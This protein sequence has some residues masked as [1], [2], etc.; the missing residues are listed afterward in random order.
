MAKYSTPIFDV[1][2]FTKLQETL[3]QQLNCE[4]KMICRTRTL[5]WFW[6]SYVSGTSES[7]E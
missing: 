1:I 7:F 3:K 4:K 5:V 6:L 2:L